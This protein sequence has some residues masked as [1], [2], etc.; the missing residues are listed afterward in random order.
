MALHGRSAWPS[1][2]S[3][4]HSPLDPVSLHLPPQPAVAFANIG[5]LAV[6][7]LIATLQAPLA[8][9]LDTPDCLPVV[10]ADAFAGA[11]PGTLA[12]AL[13]LHV[14]REGEAAAVVHPRLNTCA[15]QSCAR[16]VCQSSWP[17]GGCSCL[18]HSMLTA[19]CRGLSCHRWQHQQVVRHVG[20]AHTQVASQV[21]AAAGLARSWPSCSS[22]PPWCQAARQPS[23]RRWWPGLKLQASPDWW[24]W[25]VGVRPMPARWQG[26]PQYPTGAPAAHSGHWGRRCPAACLHEG[27]RQHCATT[28]CFGRAW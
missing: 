6:D 26:A 25:R 13:D 15:C 7:V 17:P 27:W 12:T 11:A 10:G 23:R 1:I 18:A 9:W 16:E 5:E 21:A 2:H 19:D 22:V 4:T 20:S 14:V 24:C 28:C 3:H 8:A